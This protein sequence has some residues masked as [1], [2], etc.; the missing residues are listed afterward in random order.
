MVDVE[1]EWYFLIMEYCDMGNL[2]TIQSKTTSR[3]FTLD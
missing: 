2:M 1:G 3:V